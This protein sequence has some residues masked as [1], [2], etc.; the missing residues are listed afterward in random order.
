MLDLNKPTVFIGKFCYLHIIYILGQTETFSKGSP[1]SLKE[2]YMG[3]QGPCCHC[4]ISTTPLWRNGPPEKPVLC[5]ACGSRWRTKGTLA[6]YMPMHSGGCGANGSLDYKWPRGKKVSQ[7]FK[8]QRSHK[9]KEPCDIHQEIEFRVANSNQQHAI[10][11]DEDASTRSSSVSGLSYSEGCMQHA[12]AF[13]KYNT[14]AWESP[15]PSKKRTCMFRQRPSSLENL[16]KS[17]QVSQGQDLSYLSSSSE[18]DLLYECKDQMV[19]PEI[20]LGGVFIRQPHSA[21]REEESEASSLLIDNKGYSKFDVSTQAYSGIVE[22]PVQILGDDI[23]GSERWMEM[24]ELKRLLQSCHSPLISIELE[25]IVN[26]DTFM[27]LLKEEEQQ[28][29]VKYLSSVDH[30][31]IPE[32]LKCMFNSGQF[33]GALSNFQHLLSEGMFGTYGSRLSP[34]VERL[35]QQLLNLT[36]LTDSKWMER[37]SKL[38]KDVK[39]NKSVNFSEIPECK[40]SAKKRDFGLPA[41][42]VSKPLKHGTYK[43]FVSSPG[44]LSGQVIT[45]SEKSTRNTDNLQKSGPNTVHPVTPA[46]ASCNMEGI[47]HESIDTGSTSKD[48]AGFEIKPKGSPLFGANSL[49]TSPPERC[50]SFVFESIGDFADEDSD[51]V[52]LFDVPSNLSFPQAELLHTPVLKCKTP[53]DIVS[54]VSNLENANSGGPIVNSEESLDWGGLLWNPSFVGSG[55]TLSGGTVLNP[56]KARL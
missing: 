1:R 3:K 52:L 5:N 35:F 53:K 49:F 37:Y 51:S 28:H 18:D 39:A 14:V 47:Y 9:R 56:D 21:T 16:T 27:G 31:G 17:V 46:W 30:S 38:Q 48:A 29:L 41:C 8:E 10:F 50:S 26:F 40:E 43:A 42:F 15:I 13:E 25:D 2:V 19:A 11:L 20:G 45:G 12:V 44:Q 34:Q 23:T 22:T 6:N 7:K 55:Q 33:K 54:D 24:K 36:D 32:S 4:G